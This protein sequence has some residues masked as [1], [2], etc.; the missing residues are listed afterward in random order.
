MNTK[1]LILFILL[2]VVCQI[3]QSQSIQVKIPNFDDTYC[4]TIAK[5]E[6]GE[7]EIDYLKFRESFLESQQHSVASDKSTEL[8][9]LKKKMYEQMRNSELD[10]I[11]ITT[12][13][14]LS[15]DYT[16]MKAHKILRQTYEYTGDT[17]NARKYKAIQF[18]LLNSIIDNGDGR[19]CESAWPVIAVSEEYF[20]LEMLDARLLSQSINE[21]GGICDEMKVNMEDQ[22]RVYSVSYTHL[23][24]PTKA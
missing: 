7:T 10:E 24:L 14:M 13:K 2:I 1:Q 8:I 16:N 21:D 22:E 23:T 4:H 15:I 12:K 5:L 20:I 18:G 9:E 3:G 17:T 19:S 6:S 11:I